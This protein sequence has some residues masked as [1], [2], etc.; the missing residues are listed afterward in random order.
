MILS[1]PY[2][3]DGTVRR[4]LQGPV[5]RSNRIF[6]KLLW[7]HKQ[8]LFVLSIHDTVFSCKFSFKTSASGNLFIVFFSSQF[9]LRNLFFYHWAQTCPPIEEGTWLLLLRYSWLSETALTVC[10]ELTD[11]LYRAQN[12]HLMAKM[13]KDSTWKFNST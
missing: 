9:P 10:I 6:T 8:N 2:L 11:S 5:R 4:L 7:I 3:S 1:L 13:R 12:N